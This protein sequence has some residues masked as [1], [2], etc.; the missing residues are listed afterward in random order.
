MAKIP[1]VLFVDDNVNLLNGA[2]RVARGKVDMITAESAA[3]ALEILEAD[4]TIEIVVSDQNMPAM[5]GV[6]FLAEVA[7][8]WPL[9]VRIMQTGNDD[10][11]TAMAAINAGQVFRFV[12]KPYETEELLQTIADASALYSARA[13][14]RKLFETTL[15]GSVKLMTDLMRLMRPDLFEKSARVHQLARLAAK[16][17]SVPLLW[18]LELAIM[19]YPLGLVTVPE[20]VLVRQAAHLPL[21]ARD[22]SLIDGSLQVSADLLRNIPRLE[23]VAKIIELSRRGFDGSGFP[24]GGPKG[25]DLPVASRLLLILID[26]I[27]VAAAKN[28][29]DVGAIEVLQM[30]PKRYD[31]EML[32]RVAAAI[33]AEAGVVKPKLVEQE[34]L[35]HLLRSGDRITRDVL[36]SDGKLLLSAHSILTEIV[37]QKLKYFAKAGGCADRLPVWR[38]PER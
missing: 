15:A 34:V 18:E 17:V 37:I 23:N 3:Q 16:S 22:Q 30:S 36:S 24:M 6:E 8:R 21:S 25:N 35:V 2:R 28:L 1:K 27:D 5:K 29:A 32:R 10:Q 9:I 19:L 13:S 11:A 33:K 26:V 38:E 31:P 4:N 20:A 7:R 12:R 14:E